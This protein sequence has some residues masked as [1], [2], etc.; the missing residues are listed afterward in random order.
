MLKLGIAKRITN[1]GPHLPH[2][3]AITLQ[4]IQAQKEGLVFKDVDTCENTIAVEWK[5]LSAVF[6]A[7]FVPGGQNRDGS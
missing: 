4:K 3:P 6:D 7:V 2:P 5:I 1:S